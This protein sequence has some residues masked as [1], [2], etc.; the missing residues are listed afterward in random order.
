MSAGV[1]SFF[2]TTTYTG[3]SPTKIRSSP[4]SI[5]TGSTTP[6]PENQGNVAAYSTPSH[7]T[8]TNYLQNPASV[9]GSATIT[10]ILAN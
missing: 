9:A 7:K 3:M 1:T 5:L 6:S 10:N 8:G 2:E 4:Y